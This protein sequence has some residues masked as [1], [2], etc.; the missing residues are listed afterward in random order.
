MTTTEYIKIV[1]LENAIEAQVIASVLEE[2]GIP[3]RVRSYQDTAYDG[4][5]Q[6]QKGWADLMAPPEF[7]VDVMEIV[8]GI[9]SSSA[10]SSE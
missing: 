10:S 5:F 6:F 7:R 1:V 4:L 2:R 8:D 3:H 9:R